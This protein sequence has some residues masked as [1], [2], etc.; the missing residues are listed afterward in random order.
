MKHGEEKNQ[1]LRKQQHAGWYERLGTS[2]FS[3]CSVEE[4]EWQRGVPQIDH[5]LEGKW[6]CKTLIFKQL[7]MMG[8]ARSNLNMNTKQRLLKFLF[9]LMYLFQQLSLHL[10]QMFRFKFNCFRRGINNTL[11]TLPQAF[12]LSS[13]L[14]Q[15][16]QGDYSPSNPS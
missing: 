1:W 5:P 13:P 14:P 11:M 6:L 10:L 4:R 7:I 3:A 12:S 8:S 9:Y 15:W 16:P 2:S